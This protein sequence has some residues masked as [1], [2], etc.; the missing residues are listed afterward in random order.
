MYA[1]FILTCKSC[2]C[3]ME[4]DTEHYHSSTEI[5][6]QNCGQILDPSRSEQLEAAVLS[7][8]TLPEHLNAGDG[9]IA[10]D[11]GF[12]VALKI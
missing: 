11:Q 2:L 6:C 3:S 9:W 12:H 5:R 10:P 8:Q 4:I 1:K 7:L